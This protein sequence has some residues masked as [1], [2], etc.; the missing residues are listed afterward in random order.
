M[1]LFRVS[2]FVYDKY[3]LNPRMNVLFVCFFSSLFHQYSYSIPLFSLIS[4]FVLLFIFGLFYF[5]PFSSDSYLWTAAIA[6][7]LHCFI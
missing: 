2:D 3:E 4:V 6:L 7:L 5:F 1:N